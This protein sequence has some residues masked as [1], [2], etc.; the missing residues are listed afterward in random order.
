M[1]ECDAQY[2]V[3]HLFNVGITLGDHATTHG[4]IESY[5]R[6]IGIRLT[7]WEVLTIKRLSETYLSESYKAR[8][9]NA[10]T[11]WQD[12]PYYMT[13]AYRSAMRSKASIRKLA[14]I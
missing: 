4:E 11:P 9:P 14:E 13:R 8:E 10:D 3:E 12:A 1:P 2:I 5:Q 6:N 7:P